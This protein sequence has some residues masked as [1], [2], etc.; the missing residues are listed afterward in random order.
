MFLRVRLRSLRSSSSHPI[1]RCHARA[2]CT[3]DGHA[4]VRQARAC[5]SPELWNEFLPLPASVH[6]TAVAIDEIFAGQGRFSSCKNRAFHQIKQTSGAIRCLLSVRPHRP[7]GA[8]WTMLLCRMC[9][10]L[11]DPEQC[12]FP[13]GCSCGFTSW[14]WVDST[15]APTGFDCA[16]S[17]TYHCAGS[18][19]RLGLGFSTLSSHTTV[20]S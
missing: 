15:A 16:L 2:L 6:G 13:C 18:R 3:R 4:G 9:S 1:S 10:K 11:H 20:L 7:A 5:G 12:G 17:H 19:R 14:W 8:R